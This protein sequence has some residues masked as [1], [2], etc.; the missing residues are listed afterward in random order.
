MNE[1][2]NCSSL[3]ILKQCFLQPLLFP[4]FKRSLCPFPSSILSQPIEPGFYPDHSTKTA[5]SKDWVSCFHIWRALS[6][7]RPPWRPA[8]FGTVILSPLFELSFG[9]RLSWLS[10][11][12]L[13]RLPI[14]LV[15]SSFTCPL[16]SRCCSGCSALDPFSCK[17]SLGE[18]V[19]FLCVHYFLY[20]PNSK[21][22][23]LFPKLCL[24]MQTHMI[25][26]SPSD[27]CLMFPS[28]IPHRTSPSY[29]LCTVYFIL[30]VACI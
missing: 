7:S 5:L 4:A 10:P 18:S 14:P 12:F 20:V 13:E 29:F 15:N 17:F 3:F 16:S 9:T 21:I 25:L 19:P 11:S 24:E 2:I 23:I 1:Y 8:A 27:N 6:S 26:L 30:S 22:N 28:H